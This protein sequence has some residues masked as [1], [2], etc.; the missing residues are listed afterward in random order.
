MQWVALIERSAGVKLE[1]LTLGGRCVV[2]SAIRILARSIVG[3]TSCEVL[4]RTDGEWH[5]VAQLRP[6][7]ISEQQ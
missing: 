7:N 1:P 2:N 5:I 3:V 6:S 4:L